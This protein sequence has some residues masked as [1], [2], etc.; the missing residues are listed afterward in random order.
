M[1]SRQPNDVLVEKIPEKS[2][3]TKTLKNDQEIKQLIRRFSKQTNKK[4]K[5]ET[6]LLSFTKK[7]WWVYVTGLDW[8]W[9]ERPIFRQHPWLG[10]VELTEIKSMIFG[11]QTQ[12]KQRQNNSNNT[13][14]KKTKWTIA[15][16]MQLMN[17]ALWLAPGCPEN[18]SAENPF[19][20][21]LS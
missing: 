14:A 9:M 7:R 15:Q 10:R 11:H 2:R 17:H 16:S 21:P 5:P 3:E 6:V 20:T 19:S 8:L 12:M 4:R 18:P 13:K 1:L